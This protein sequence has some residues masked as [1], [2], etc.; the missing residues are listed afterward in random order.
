MPLSKIK[1]YVEDEDGTY[2]AK[3]DLSVLCMNQWKD[4]RWERV[5][6]SLQSREA[7]KERFCFQ[8]ELPRMSERIPGKSSFVFLH[9]LMGCQQWAVFSK[10]T[11]CGRMAMYY[12]NTTQKDRL[13]MTMMIKQ[14]DSL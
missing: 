11:T 3:D 5:Q 4:D 10:S 2:L 12:G 13:L 1:L 14:P 8:D 6:I 7:D 9:S